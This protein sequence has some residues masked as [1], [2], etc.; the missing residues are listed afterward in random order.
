MTEKFVL[1]DEVLIKATVIDP[2][3]DIDGDLYVQIIGNGRGLYVTPSDLELVTNRAVPIAFE[4]I[5]VGDVV[6]AKK[7]VPL[8][9]GG[10]KTENFSKILIVITDGIVLRSGEAWFVREDG[11]EFELVAHKNS[12]PINVGDKITLGQARTLAIGSVLSSV[13]DSDQHLFTVSSNGLF[14]TTESTTY[15][16]INHLKAFSSFTVKYVAEES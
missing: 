8:R 6:N 2:V 3:P 15:S 13:V 7:T 9:N 12:E 11:Y 16:W 5:R 1:G 10:E 14:D 4:D